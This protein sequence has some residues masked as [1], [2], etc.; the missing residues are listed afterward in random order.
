MASGSL[1]LLVLAAAVAAAS[2]QTVYQTGIL[3]W[4]GMNEFGANGASPRAV[5]TP[6]INRVCNTNGVAG[7]QNAFTLTN[8]SAYPT[9]PEF[10]LDLPA[11]TGCFVSVLRGREWGPGCAPAVLLHW[12][13]SIASGLP[14]H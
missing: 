12:H 9:G 5:K 13:R 1:K 6:N 8:G 14:V 3:Y 2:A 11:A 7:T 4:C 10:T